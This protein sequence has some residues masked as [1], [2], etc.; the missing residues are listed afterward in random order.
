MMN[1]IKY[2]DDDIMIIMT[3]MT[4]TADMMNNRL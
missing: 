1:I 2:H 4:I 3:K